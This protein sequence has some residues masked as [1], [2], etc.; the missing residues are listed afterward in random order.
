[1]KLDN[2]NP[3]SNQGK[4]P[5]PLR[6]EHDVQVSN[7]TSLI[8]ALSIVAVG[9]VM[10]LFKRGVPAS[11][12]EAGYAGPLGQSVEVGHETRDLNTCGI[13]AIGCL[14]LISMAVILAIATGVLSLLSG[15][16]PQLAYPPT[17][18]SNAP[19]PTLPPQPQLEAV[20]GQSLEQ[21]R[22]QEDK[23]LSTY[24]WIDKSA[25]VVRIPITRAMDIIAQKGLPA[26]SPSEAQKYSD[27]GQ[28]LPSVSSSGRMEERWLPQ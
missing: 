4:E 28:S 2:S 27:Q 6:P 21:L 23:L 16:L 24:G 8:V 18:L 14:F 5:T 13:A 3:G 20:P 7:K 26:R 25:G 11:K 1:V 9:V 15:Q 12:V 10:G 17:G 22:A 19:A